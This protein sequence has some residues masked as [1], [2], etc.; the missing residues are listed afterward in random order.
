MEMDGLSIQLRLSRLEWR[1]RWH[2]DM[3][4]RSPRIA[5]WNP[6]VAEYDAPMKRERG[7]VMDDRR[8]SKNPRINWCTDAL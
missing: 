3:M 7:E 8:H 4:W 6:Y 2:A 5:E 1:A